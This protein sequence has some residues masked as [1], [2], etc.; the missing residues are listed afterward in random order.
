LDRQG[1]DE[2]VHLASLA[3]L[4]AK[5]W[6]PADALIDGLSNTDRDLRQEILARSHI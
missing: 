3:A 1:K 2:R 6:S 5:G 4:V